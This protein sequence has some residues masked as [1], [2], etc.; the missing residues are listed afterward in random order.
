MR[1]YLASLLFIIPPQVMS[2]KLRVIKQRFVI[3]KTYEVRTISFQTFFR[4]GI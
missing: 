2:S 1:Q 4:V 3:L